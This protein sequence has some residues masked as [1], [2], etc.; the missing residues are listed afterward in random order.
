MPKKQLG[1]GAR[2]VM[3]CTQRLEKLRCL[4]VHMVI[5]RYCVLLSRPPA[6]SGATKAACSGVTSFP[7]ATKACS[8]CPR[9]HIT[10]EHKLG[11]SVGVMWVCG[12]PAYCTRCWGEVAPPNWRSPWFLAQ[13]HRY[14]MCRSTL[15]TS[16]LC[17]KGIISACNVAHQPSSGKGALRCCL[18]WKS[19]PGLISSPGPLIHTLV[20]TA[21][22]T[23]IAAIYAILQA[24]SQIGNATA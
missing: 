20:N 14:S 5:Q 19:L 10:H 15:P 9:R 1:R 7:S 11:R 13:N 21:H 6:Q 8:V 16:S 4:K 23:S 17:S 22:P 18:Y 2:E 24:L 12:Y 3:E